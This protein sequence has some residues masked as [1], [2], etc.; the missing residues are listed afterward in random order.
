MEKGFA[1]PQETAAAGVGAVGSV[2]DCRHR[3]LVEALLK[4]LGDGPVTRVTDV[5]GP[6]AGGLQALGA[7]LF[8]Q[9]QEVLHTACHGSPIWRH[10]GDR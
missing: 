6:L 3:F 4:D 7:A 2:L 9:A 8:A 10:I 5:Q 1:V